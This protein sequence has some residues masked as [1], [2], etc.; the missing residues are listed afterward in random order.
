MFIILATSIYWHYNAES[1]GVY[2]N[3]ETPGVYSDLSV[4]FKLGVYMENNTLNNS[5]L[6]S[7]LSIDS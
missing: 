7:N 6:L 1:P 4:L 2:S 3:A 5:Q